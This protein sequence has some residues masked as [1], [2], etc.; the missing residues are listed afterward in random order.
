MYLSG[1][2]AQSIISLPPPGSLRSR[3]RCAEGC[4]VL[5]PVLGRLLLR[6]R[7]LPRARSR[8]IL[9]EISISDR[10]YTLP[11]AAAAAASEAPA[12][13]SA[14]KAAAISRAISA[15][16]SRGFSR[17]IPLGWAGEEAPGRAVLPISSPSISSPSMSSWRH[18][19][20]PLFFATAA[21]PAAGH[22]RRRPAAVPSRGHREA[23]LLHGA[24][25]RRAARVRSD[26]ATAAAVRDALLLRSS[27][28][29][30]GEQSNASDAVESALVAA[31]AASGPAR[32][33]RRPSSTAAASWPRRKT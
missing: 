11:V 28:S 13:V 30:V 8:P 12:S 22:A 19:L 23:G 33:S 29:P 3:L 9:R 25:A 1:G 15:G 14:R 20:P 6:G 7:P 4:A 18:L 2:V 21:L 17:A 32:R 10:A 27:G 26:A 5:G 16:F 31:Q 24:A